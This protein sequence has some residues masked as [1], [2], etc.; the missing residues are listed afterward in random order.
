MKLIIG[1]GNPEDKYK[2]TRH[3]IGFEYLDYLSKKYSFDFKQDKKFQALCC[4]INESTQKKIFNKSIGE[5]IILVKPLTYMNLSGSC[6]QKFCSFYKI[7]PE[8]ILE[9]SVRFLI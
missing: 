5:S 4:E 9:C 7:K 1:L 6:V 3:N 8:N 2:S